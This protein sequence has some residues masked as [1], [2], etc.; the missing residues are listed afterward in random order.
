MCSLMGWCS[1]GLLPEDHFDVC[2]IDE[3]GQSLE[4]AC[5]TALLNA[6]CCVLAGDHLQLPPT[7][8]SPEAVCQMTTHPPRHLPL[9]RPLSHPLHQIDA[10]LHRPD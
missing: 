2:V 1:P 8:S 4:V 5:W 3:A 7:I 9:S 6:P 10:R